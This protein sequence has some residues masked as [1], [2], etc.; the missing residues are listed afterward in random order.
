MTYMHTRLSTSMASDNAI[1]VSAAQVSQD[2]RQAAQDARDAARE[3]ARIAREG[4][5]QGASGGNAGQ[6][7]VQ[8]PEPPPLPALPP[9]PRVPGTIVIPTDGDADIRINVDGSGIHV[10]QGD[11]TT[12]IPITDIVPRG[13]VDIVQAM[14]ATLVLIVV[15]WPLARA[16]ARWLDRRHSGV[17][18]S[19]AV[20]ARLEAMDRNIDT[21]AIELERISEGQRF[22]AKLLEQR[23]TEHAQ[24]IDR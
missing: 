21:V 3:A 7:S 16:F 6:L 2:V 12:T 1:P 13:A 10:H 5:S 17:L 20:E 8:P 4:V 22:T 23:S 18:L 11:A 9:V 24:R 14:G 19:K 15:G